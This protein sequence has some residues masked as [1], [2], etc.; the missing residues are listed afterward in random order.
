MNAKIR[1][2]HQKL[3][4]K[5]R[6]FGE[7]I[8]DLAPV[9]SH[10]VMENIKAA[11]LTAAKDQR[12]STVSVQ[13]VGVPGKEPGQFSVQLNWDLKTAKR[14]RTFETMT[15]HDDGQM[16]FEEVL[17]GEVGD[18]DDDLED[19]EPPGVQVMKNQQAHQE[20]V[21]E[22]LDEKAKQAG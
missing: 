17:E 20:K 16:T 9:E 5:A 8:E 15:L 2:Q 12:R 21:A 11:M 10:H 14:Q 13:I 1:K 22:E 7:F 3:G 4:I 19:P 18:E 6:T